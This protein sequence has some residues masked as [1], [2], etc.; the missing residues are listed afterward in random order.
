MSNQ[1]IASQLLQHA[2]ALSRCGG[3]LYRVRAHR[4]AALAVQG[5]RESV[6]ELIARSGRRALEA[7]PG[8]GRSLAESIGHFVATGKWP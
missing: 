4:Q 3:N 7:V 6:P 8:I 1:D 5:L 2:R